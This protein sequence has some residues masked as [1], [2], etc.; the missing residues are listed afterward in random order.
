MSGRIYTRTGD[1]GETGLFGGGRVAKSHPRVEAYGAVDELNANLGLAA[2]AI[3]DEPLLDRIRIIQSD[4]FTIGAHLATPPEGGEKSRSHLPGLPTGRVAEME[5]WIDDL[6]SGLEPLR[7]FVLPGGSSTA[8][9][10]HVCRTVCR[11]AER[12]VVA[13]AGVEAVEPMI[14]VLLNRISDFLFVAARSANRSAGVDDTP[15]DPAGRSGR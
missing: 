7:T 2:C 10:L 4:L 14:V 3:G 13:L 15:W 9:T 6:E 12:R 5:A 11:R 1:A 8:A